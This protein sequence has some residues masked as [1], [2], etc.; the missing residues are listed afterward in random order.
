LT[1]NENILQC[2][3]ALIATATEDK[4]MTKNDQV[5]RSWRTFAVIFGG[6]L[7][8]QTWNLQKMES[9]YWKMGEMLIER[10]LPGDQ[11]ILKEG[12]GEVLVLPDRKFQYTVRT[13]VGTK[14]FIENAPPPARSI[15]SYSL[16]ER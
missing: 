9:D 15:F 4:I 14:I 5:D 11:Y 3:V 6:I 2:L 10:S 13:G 7:M 12:G 1:I 8:S 16:Q